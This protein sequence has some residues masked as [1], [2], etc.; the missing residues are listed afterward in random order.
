LTSPLLTSSSVW[1]TH[2]GAANQILFQTTGLSYTGYASSNIGGAA[3]II[4]GSGSRQDINWII[5][6]SISSGNVYVSFLLNVSVAGGSGTTSDYI[7]HLN[8]TSG[9]ILPNNVF[10][11]RVFIRDGSSP[12]TFQIGVNK[13]SSTTSTVWTT[14]NYNLNST[15]LVVLKYIFLPSSTTNDNVYA[16]IFSSGI[17]A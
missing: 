2:S 11:A 12:S 16:W 1:K 8:D 13:G 10:R 3:A 17:P 7:F 6:I 4:N 5:P 9:N 15:H 14:T